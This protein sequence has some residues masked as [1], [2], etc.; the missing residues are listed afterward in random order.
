[1]VS[2]GISSP[3][4]KQSTYAKLLHPLHN[5]KKHFLPTLIKLLNSW[6]F[7]L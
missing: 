4:L 6:G 1:M 2:A 3:P 7:E 5:L